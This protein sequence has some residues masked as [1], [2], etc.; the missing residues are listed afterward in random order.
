MDVDTLI[1]QRYGDI[2]IIKS[3]IP[4][5]LQDLYPGRNTNIDITDVERLFVENAKNIVMNPIVEEEEDRLSLDEE[6]HHDMDEVTSE[7]HSCNQAC[8]TE[9]DV[10]PTLSPL[11]VSQERPTYTE[12][13]ANSY[14]R[15]KAEGMQQI[16]K[17]DI[18]KRSQEV[19]WHEID[20]PD[21]SISVGDLDKS[22]NLQVYATDRQEGFVSTSI[23]P[24]K[25]RVPYGESLVQH[26]ESGV[27][28][29]ADFRT[30]DQQVSVHRYGDFRRPHQIDSKPEMQIIANKLDF[31]T[32]SG[33]HVKIERTEASYIPTATTLPTPVYKQEYDKDKHISDLNEKIK[34]LESEKTSN[35]KKF[36]MMLKGEK[37]H[38]KRRRRIRIYASD[39]GFTLTEE[40]LDSFS[41]K[42]FDYIYT[43]VMKARNKN[44]Y[45]LVY[46]TLFIN[47]L[48]IANRVLKQKKVGIDLQYIIDSIT[49]DVFIEEM[50]DAMPEILT[51]T[52]TT[53]TQT[54]NP[55]VKLLYLVVVKPV[56][57][58]L[59]SMLMGSK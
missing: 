26:N 43:S 51:S 4:I 30:P 7:I 35:A 22:R 29:H 42:E 53:V 56:E 14:E 16:Q 1:T 28:R 54:H 18:G 59:P 50:E 58:K 47:G 57:I 21:E 2:D 44:V 49:S 20:K 13:V 31:V 11:G 40:D 9:I 45:L 41:Q 27:R 10:V 37:E 25:C 39:H 33:S 8:D 19:P 52:I 38:D 24:S 6:A 12:V 55:L 17:T 34:Q 15:D 3:T 48:R 32:P 46:Y 36:L 5:V 23:A